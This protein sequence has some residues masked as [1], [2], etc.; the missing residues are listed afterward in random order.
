MMRGQKGIT[1]I[2]LVITIIV[3]LILVVVSVTVAL[4]GGLFTSAKSAATNT[5]AEQQAESQLSNG[6]INVDGNLYQIDDYAKNATPNNV[7][8]SAS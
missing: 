3:M 6:I 2:A 1:L 5:N 7:N 8:P 4:Q